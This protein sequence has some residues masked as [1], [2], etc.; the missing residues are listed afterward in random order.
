MLTTPTFRPECGTQPGVIAHRRAGEAYCLECRKA[1][2]AQVGHDRMA[3][4]DVGLADLARAA[5]LDVP[6]L[7]G[8]PPPPP[9][10]RSR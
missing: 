6:Q 7:R 5:G 2:G 10:R 9:R 8:I 3:G 4:L 1:A